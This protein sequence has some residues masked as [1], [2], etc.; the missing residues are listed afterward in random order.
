MHKKNGEGGVKTS[1]RDDISDLLVYLLARDGEVA[2]GVRLLQLASHHLAHDLDL[3]PLAQLAAS[4]LHHG[5][6]LASRCGG[7]GG[8]RRAAG[9]A[10]AGESG[11]E[12]TEG[13]GCVGGPEGR[14]RGRRALEGALRAATALGTAG[15]TGGRRRRRCGVHDGCHALGPSFVAALCLARGGTPLSAYHLTLTKFQSRSLILTFIFSLY[16]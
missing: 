3:G 7:K 9:R 2:H 1:P 8:G 13:R 5:P 14:R 12:E 11:G 6:A 10:L 4:V 16:I 15:F